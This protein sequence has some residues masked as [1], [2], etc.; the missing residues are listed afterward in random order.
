MVEIV[1]E[2]CIGCGLCVQ[3]CLA[4]NLA[5]EKGKAAVRGACLEC[6]HCF[7]VC[8]AKA[9]CISG[10][11]SDG[12]VEFENGVHNVSGDEFLRLVKSRRSIRNY[13][14]RCISKE[15]WTK[16]L[17]AGRFTAT[18]ANRQDVK[19][20]VVQDELETVK[21][22]VWT[23]F[24]AMTEQMKRVQGEADPFVQKLQG[25]NAVYQTSPQKDPLFFNAP[26]LL[27]ITSE[28]SLNGGLAAS[29]IEL[30]A[31]AEG[32][33]VLYSGFIQRGLAAS[34]EG[35]DYLGIDKTK[36][37]ACMLAGYPNVKYQRSVPRKTAEIQ[38]K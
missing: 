35:C 24:A 12:I 27:V 1:K 26:S 8:P 36:I 23:G 4:K 31:H 38:W 11:P 34:D 3:D 9:V 20:V 7:A 21:K 32:L 15:T 5:V 19:Y 29:N 28:S 22:F 37:C 25:M 6:G 18:A 14:E 13:Q 10:Y 2:K 16:I 17:E 30:M 33:G